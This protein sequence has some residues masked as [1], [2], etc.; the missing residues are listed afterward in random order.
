MGMVTDEWKDFEIE[1]LKENDVLL[2]ILPH[3]VTGPVVALDNLS[4]Q[5]EA[6]VLDLRAYLKQRPDISK[7]VHQ[8]AKLPYRLDDVNR[9]NRSRSSETSKN[10]LTMELRN[11]KLVSVIGDYCVCF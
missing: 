11:I 5:F 8:E 2:I 4:P 3:L 9:R 7:T 10:E 6:F 1:F